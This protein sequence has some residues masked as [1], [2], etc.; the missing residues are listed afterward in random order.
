[1]R[2][3]EL[4]GMETTDVDLQRGLA[5]IRRGKGGKGRYVPF[6]PHTGQAI[7]RYLRARRTHRQA[8]TGKLWLGANNWRDFN[9]HGLRHALAG[10]ATRAGIANFHLHKM[11]RTYATRWL[12]LACRSSASPLGC[13][14]SRDDDIGDK[15]PAMNA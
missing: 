8:D 12:R 1:M 9:Y 7:D 11:R 13:S 6:G 4:T 10:R 15:S 3:G 2:A 14:R 5:T